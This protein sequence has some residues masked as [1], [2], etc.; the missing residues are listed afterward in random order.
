[1]HG[2][3]TIKRSSKQA[4]EC[5]LFVQEHTGMWRRYFT[6]NDPKSSVTYNPAAVLTSKYTRLYFWIRGERWLLFTY[7]QI[8]WI[9]NIKSRQSISEEK[10]CLGD[11]HMDCKSCWSE[12][13]VNL[14]GPL[15]PS[16]PPFMR[17]SHSSFHT[18]VQQFYS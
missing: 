6:D 17:A 11:S 9:H 2:R 10:W 12:A 4:R 5:Q 1:M 8:V 13:P 3:V 7:Y 15:P 14:I 16:P 18:C